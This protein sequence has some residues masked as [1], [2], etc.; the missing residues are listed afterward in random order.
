MKVFE[1]DKIRNIVVAGHG[2][3]GKTTLVSSLLYSGGAV[4][5][6]GRVEDGTTVTDYDEDE[7]ERKITINT[8]VAYCEWR[9]LKIN[10]LDT[11]GYRAFILDAKAAMRAGEAALIVVDAVAG[12]EV[13]TETVWNFASEDGIPRAFVIN[14]MDR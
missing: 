6:M 14:K 1:S 3:T 12:S 4:N 5:R 13:Q 10:L 9:G 2:D 7:I 8:S 11:P